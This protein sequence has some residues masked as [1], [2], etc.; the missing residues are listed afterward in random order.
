M[1]FMRY[2]FA[3]KFLIL[4]IVMISVSSGYSIKP[5]ISSDTDNQLDSIIEKAGKLALVAVNHDS[6]VILL[7]K[8]DQLA[9]KDQNRHLLSGFISYHGI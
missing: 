3:I 5:T 1:S 6:V 7:N 4:I 8:A 2:S 9:K